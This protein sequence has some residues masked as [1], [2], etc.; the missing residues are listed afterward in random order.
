MINNIKGE[1]RIDLSYSIQNFDSDKQIAVITMLNNN[2]KYEI[3]KL[4]AV[5]DPISN[6]KK[7]IPSGTYAGR[8]LLSIVEG[9]IELNQF[10]VDDQITKMNKLKGITEMIINLDELNN[11][12]N[13]KDGRPSNEL[14]TYHVTDDKDFTCFEPQT[15][16]YRKLKNGEFTSLNLRIMDQNNN[17]I[18]DG[19]QVTVVFHICDQKYNPLL[20]M[21]YEK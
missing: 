1:K 13:L 12:V 15:P 6:T 3:L 7:T 20:K 14:L 21:K 17:I 5:M 8:Q 4:R 16:Q 10:E 2:V 9:I 11:S 18:T 19:P